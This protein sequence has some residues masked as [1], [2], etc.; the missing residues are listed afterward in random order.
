MK[1]IFAA[2]LI[3][4]LALIAI[5]ATSV[6]ATDPIPGWNGTIKTHEGVN[7]PDPV[8]RD[9]P[10]FCTFHI[11]ALGFDSQEQVDWWII[12]GEPFN[13]TPVLTDTIVTDTDGAYVSTVIT[14]SPDHYKLFWAGEEAGGAKHKVFKVECDTPPASASTEPST[15]PSMT[16]S[17]SPS[18]SPSISPSPS[19]S[20]TPTPS[21]DGPKLTPPPTD[22][23]GAVSFL[24]TAAG[25]YLI[26]GM[27]GGIIGLVVLLYVLNQWRRPTFR[28]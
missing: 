18:E 5:G 9:D 10:K 11:H 27:I 20:L 6:N 25:L 8:T 1:K 13:S 12:K 3:A 24:A 23:E 26:F 19:E 4:L 21:V 15:I 14:L 22:T 7:E 28:K 16:P 2:G 17:E